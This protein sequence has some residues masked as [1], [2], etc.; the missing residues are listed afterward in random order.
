MGN[1]RNDAVKSKSKSKALKQY[2]S[3]YRF[4]EYNH[5]D[6]EVDEFRLNTPIELENGTIVMHPTCTIMQNAHTRHI[7]KATIAF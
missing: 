4:P 6:I 3:R 5:W 7:V 2:R 1:Q